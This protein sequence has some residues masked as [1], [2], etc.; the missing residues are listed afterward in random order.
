MLRKFIIRHQNPWQLLIA[1]LGAISGLFILLLSV[2]L[3]LDFEKVLTEQ[4]D[5]IG[6][7]YI[8][9]NKEVSALSTAGYGSTAFEQWEI[10]DLEDQDFI[11][12]VGVFSS[13]LFKAEAFREAGANTPKMRSELFFEAVN[14]EFIDV[15][16]ESWEWNEG[17]SIIPVIVSS[18]YLNLYNYGFAPSQDLPQIS[19]GSLKKLIK[20][21]VEISGNGKKETMHARIAGF[22]DRIN[23]ILVPQ[24]FLDWANDHYGNKEP[25]PPSR[26]ILVSNDPSNPALAEYLDQ[27]GYKTNKEKLKNSKLNSILQGIMMALV[28]LGSIIIFVSLLGFVQY[29]QLIVFR[30]AYEIKVLIAIGHNYKKLARKYASF[31]MFVFGVVGLITLLLVMLFKSMLSSSISETTGVVL[32]EQLALI[33]YL[34]C[35]GFLIFYMIMNSLSILKSIRTMA[36]NL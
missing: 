6:S 26:L 1:V 19:E 34:V 14:E 7:D 30:S 13:N 31:F 3:Y 33:T 11:E 8:V 5:L 32:P 24:T 23:S 27:N 12:R 17:D 20:F 16:E 28:V 35:I 25:L 9:I 18:E 4:K 10:E 22:S 36:R 15:N 2:Q 21:D 29:G